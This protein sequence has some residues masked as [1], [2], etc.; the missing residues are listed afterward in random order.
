ALLDADKEGFQR[1][2]GSRIQ[3]IGMCAR[4]INGR[5]ILYADTQT[6][7]M[8]RAL[9]E[10]NRRPAIQQAYNEANGI[11]PESIVRPLSMSLAS[12]VEADYTDLTSEVDGIQE[13]KSPEELDAYIA[14]LEKDLSEAAN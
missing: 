8:E 12:I 14:R 2:V 1:S 10:T 6:D 5:A 9:D 7:S 3:P 13:L 4:I 11:T